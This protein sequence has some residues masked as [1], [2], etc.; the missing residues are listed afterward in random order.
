MRFADTD[1]EGWLGPALTAQLDSLRMSQTSLC[2][3]VMRKH[4]PPQKVYFGLIPSA[5][6]YG[7]LLAEVLGN[8]FSLQ[9]GCVEDA[10]CGLQQRS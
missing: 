5:Q 8:L 3:Q 1:N 7:A 9:G 10:A 2:K 6:P 4:S